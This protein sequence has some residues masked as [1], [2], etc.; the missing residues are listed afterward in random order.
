MR[1]LSFISILLLFTIVSCQNKQD[2]KPS[3]FDDFWEQTIAELNQTPL[4]IEKVSKD[5]II[6]G[7][8]MNLYKIRSF[9]DIDFYTWVSEPLG[10]GKFP[11][12]IRFSGLGELNFNK[13]KIA[14]LWFLKEK[15]FINMLVDIRGQGLSNEQIKPKEY[16]TEGVEKN[17]NYIYRGA[18]MDAVRAVDFISLNKK[19]NDQIV[20]TGGSQGGTLSV[21]AAALNKKVSLC[22]ANFPFLT[23]IQNYNKKEWPMKIFLHKA[24]EDQIDYFKLKNTLSYFDL[25]NFANKIQVPVFIR[26]EETD[27]ITPPE[28]AV[29]LYNLINNQK[30]VLYMEPCEGH[31]CSTNS[32]IAN[33][34]EKIFI[35]ANL[36]D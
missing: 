11:V 23:N 2:I 33:E 10:N 32:S 4:E 13:N 36:T 7:K 19:S 28:G 22:V 9:Q 27:N 25:L 3:D 12:K 31:G 29:Q 20:V 1:Y 16:V 34:M 21:V 24:K 8:R 26:T 17:E 15:G 30:K 35:K 6:E 5:S 14:H 18:Y